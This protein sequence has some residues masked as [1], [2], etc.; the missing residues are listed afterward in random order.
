MTAAFKKGQEVTYITSWDDK[1]TVCYIQ[2]VVHSCGTQQMT[3]LRADNGKLLG[4]HYAPERGRM[5]NE[6]IGNTRY[7]AGGTFPRLTGNELEAA[8]L[9]IA[10]EVLKFEREHYA[11]CLAGGHG[12]GYDASIRRDLEALHEPRMIER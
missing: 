8:C 6:V 2:A 3:L 10:A 11:R 7:K 5:N 1:G 12:V 4:R 9:H